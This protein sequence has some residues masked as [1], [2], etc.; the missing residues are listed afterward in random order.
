MDSTENMGEPP[1]VPT[2]VHVDHNQRKWNMDLEEEVE[3][4]GNVSSMKEVQRLV[5]ALNQFVELAHFEFKRGSESGRKRG[6]RDRRDICAGMSPDLNQ[7]MITSINRSYK[8]FGRVLR[9][10][11]QHMHSIIL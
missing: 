10:N 11:I 7:N 8:D 6:M 1:G 4:M 5:Q 9:L 3:N 2:N